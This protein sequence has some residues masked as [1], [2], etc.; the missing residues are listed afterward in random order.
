MP[1]QRQTLDSLD[2]AQ[3]AVVEALEGPVVIYA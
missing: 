3:R 2:V 1:G